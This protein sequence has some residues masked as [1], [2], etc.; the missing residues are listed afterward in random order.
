MSVLCIRILRRK[1]AGT[2]KHPVFRLNSLQRFTE[3]SGVGLI[4]RLAKCFAG[5]SRSGS[6]FE[7]L[8]LRR[9]SQLPSWLAACLLKH[10]DIAR[11]DS[12]ASSRRS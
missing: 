8:V 2:R 3:H 10:V 9:V 6:L 5:D 12:G 11:R 7:A 1:L 4:T